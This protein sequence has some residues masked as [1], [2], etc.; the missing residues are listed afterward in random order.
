MQ[1]VMSKYKDMFFDRYFKNKNGTLLQP[2]IFMQ[3]GYF[4]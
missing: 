4:L 3:L 2:F 1:L